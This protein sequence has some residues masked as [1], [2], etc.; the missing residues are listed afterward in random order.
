M[1]SA[2]KEVGLAHE[3]FHRDEKFRIRALGQPPL[4]KAKAMA[5]ASGNLRRETQLRRRTPLLLEIKPR[6][7]PTLDLDLGNQDFP[8]TRK[9]RR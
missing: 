8:K 3:E 5:N 1:L 7:Q 6:R 9:M 4:E 2:I